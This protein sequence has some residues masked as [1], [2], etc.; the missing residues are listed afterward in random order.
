MY[1]RHRY[2]DPSSGRF[3]SKDAIGL[4]GGINVYQ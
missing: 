1:N 2:Y 3:V 4:A